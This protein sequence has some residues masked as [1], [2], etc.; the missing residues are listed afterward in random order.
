MKIR[1]TNGAKPLLIYNEQ[2]K[3]AGLKS[4]KKS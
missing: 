4:D 3:V 1:L 2:P